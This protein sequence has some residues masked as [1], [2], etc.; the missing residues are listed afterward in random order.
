MTIEV[1]PSW[2]TI[3][4]ASVYAS[5]SCSTIRAWLGSGLASTK[6]SPHIR[7]IH[8]ADIDAFLVKTREAEGSVHSGS[9]MQ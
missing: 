5:V 2:L 1:K 9:N 3:R 4:G 6:P 7:L 8:T